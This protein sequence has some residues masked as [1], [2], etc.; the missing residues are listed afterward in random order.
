MGF[1][2]EVISK[3]SLLFLLP[4]SVILFYGTLLNMV[5]LNVQ[6]RNSKLDLTVLLILRPPQQFEKNI[7]FIVTYKILE[8]QRYFCDTMLNILH[9][10]AL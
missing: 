9:T 4:F 5:V 2:W 8:L 1:F 10:Y 6:Y 7:E 3:F